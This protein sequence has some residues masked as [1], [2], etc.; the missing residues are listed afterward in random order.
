MGN[1]GQKKHRNSFS[2]SFF[3]PPPPPQKKTIRDP[4]KKVDVPHLPGKEHK[5]GTHINIFRGILGSKGGSQTGH[6]GPQKVKF[7]LLFFSLP[8][9]NAR[10]IGSLHVK[11]PVQRS[12]L[13]NVSLDCGFGQV[14]LSKTHRDGFREFLGEMWVLVGHYLWH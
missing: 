7:N 14:S 2:I 11:L 12:D 8:L 10:Q 6:F 3:A 13:A 9:R 4:Q 5:K 1:K